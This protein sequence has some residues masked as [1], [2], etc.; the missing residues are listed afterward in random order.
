MFA[1]SRGQPNFSDIVGDRIVPSAWNP[2]NTQNLGPSS[3]SGH[4]N[5]GGQL[6]P[7]SGDVSKPLNPVRISLFLKK[8]TFCFCPS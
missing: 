8:T 6:F 4:P 1:L 5:F 7:K 3:F 2:M